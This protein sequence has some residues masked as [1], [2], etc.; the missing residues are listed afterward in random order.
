MTVSLVL[1][2]IWAV[3]ASVIAMLP[4]RIHWP[5]AYALIVVG[6]PILG[7]V[8]YQNGPIMGLLVLAGGVS[9]LRWPVLFLFRWLRGQVTGQPAE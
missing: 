8:T 1:A 6:I 4:N 5:A 9:I 2:C 3:V 7:F